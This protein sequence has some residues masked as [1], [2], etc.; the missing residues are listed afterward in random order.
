[1]RATRTL[2]ALLLALAAAASAA[3]PDAPASGAPEAGGLTGTADIPVGGGKVFADQKIVVTQPEQGQFKAFTAVCPH[4]GCLVDAVQDGVIVCPCHDSTF[5]VG[6]GAVRQG[7]ATQPLAEV[8]ITV[9]GDRIA[10]A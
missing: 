7:P 8:P 3:A 10:M 5:A 6:D 9:S 1:M 2:T 4:R